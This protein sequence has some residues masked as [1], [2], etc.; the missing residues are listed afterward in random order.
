V[1]FFTFLFFFFLAGLL[2][3]KR[4]SR[5]RSLSPGFFSGCNFS[6]GPPPKRSNCL[7]PET[8]R[9]I[10]AFPLPGQKPLPGDPFSPSA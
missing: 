7:V 4:D 8:S 6:D 10:P 9:L 1:W 3:L 2:I 5:C